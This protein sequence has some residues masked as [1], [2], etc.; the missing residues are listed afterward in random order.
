VVVAA[1]QEAVSFGHSYVGSE[2]LLL[3]V[4]QQ[5]DGAMAAIGLT[6]ERIRAHIVRI[7]GSGERHDSDAQSI[8]FTPHAKS[9]LD[10]ASRTSVIFGGNTIEPEHI[11]IA[12]VIEEGGGALRILRDCDLSPGDIRRAVVRD[13]VDR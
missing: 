11:L 1:L 4:V 5:D 9:A 12:L 8:P 6:P 13:L 7:F 3:G 2:H 10:W